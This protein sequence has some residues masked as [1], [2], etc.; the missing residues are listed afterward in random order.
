MSTLEHDISDITEGTR[1][2]N[3]YDYCDFNVKISIMTPRF[4]VSLGDPISSSAS[5]HSNSGSKK[6][7]FPALKK[8]ALEI[9]RLENQLSFLKDHYFGNYAIKFILSNKERIKLRSGYSVIKKRF[10]DWIIYNDISTPIFASQIIN[11]LAEIFK[12]E[13]QNSGKIRA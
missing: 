2:S 13:N 8:Q 4:D 7:K 3:S 9:D 11:Y 5:N 12:K 6:L 1:R 10:L